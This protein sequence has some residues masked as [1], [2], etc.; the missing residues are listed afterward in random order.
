MIFDILDQLGVAIVDIE[1][2]PGLDVALAG[3]PADRAHQQAPERRKP[4]RKDVA[5]ENYADSLLANMFG[6][7]YAA[8]L[9][10][11][12]HLALLELNDGM[13][14]GSER[15][16]ICKSPSCTYSIMLALSL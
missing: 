3:L 15:D 10:A 16:V 14:E 4:W 2:G 12:E 5:A 11:G 7:I 9:P 8:A 13:F 1:V 6:S